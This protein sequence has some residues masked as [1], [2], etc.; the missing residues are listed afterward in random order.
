MQRKSII[1]QDETAGVSKSQL[2]AVLNRL[3]DPALV[4]DDA[5]R[6]VGITHHAET[7]FGYQR[8]ELL[9]DLKTGGNHGNRR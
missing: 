7:L 9:G 4:V 8:D 2:T 6:T 3:P 5:A 1:L